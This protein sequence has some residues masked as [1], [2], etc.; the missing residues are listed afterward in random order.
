MSKLRKRL[1]VVAGIVTVLFLILFLFRVSLLNG[2]A[3]VLIIEEHPVKSDVIIV[4]GGERYGERTKKA[5]A[6]YE[7]DYAKRLLFS[8]GTWLSWRVRAID[9][10]T[11]LAAHLKVPQEAVY[12]EDRSRSTYENA[13]LTRT[14]V[15]EQGWTSAIV[16]TT[17]WHT[18]RSRMIFD[19][20]FKDSG[21]TL[22]YARA[23]DG[24]NDDLHE[25]WRDSEEQQ[26]VLTEWARLV[27]YWLQYLVF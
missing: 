15:L 10:M 1:I 13:V 9:E 3:D 27:V 2:L 23:K 16:V 8:D 12:L 11:A 14:I 22:S 18:R 6:L 17:D 20:V 24:I 21:I 4:L 5:V 19:H 7:L 26:T 25:W